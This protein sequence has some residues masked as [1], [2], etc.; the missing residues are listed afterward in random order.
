MGLWPKRMAQDE[1][2]FKPR[3]AYVSVDCKVHLEDTVPPDGL[4]VHLDQGLERS[5]RH[6]RLEEPHVLCTHA[7]IPAESAQQTPTASSAQHPQ[8]ITTVLDAAGRLRE[9]MNWARRC[10]AAYAHLQ[11][12][13]A[14]FWHPDLAV[15]GR[16]VHP[17]R[18]PDL[19]ATRQPGL[20]ADPTHRRVHDPC[21][22]SNE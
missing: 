17:A 4:V 6:S 21:S 1:S 5:D 8:V 18:A 14:R 16:A 12:G 22:N 15:L 9:L 7:K 13:V 19:L 10:V 2:Q 11:G 20:R 3:I